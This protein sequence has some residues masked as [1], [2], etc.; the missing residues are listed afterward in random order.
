MNA[1][2]Q[3]I[4]TIDKVICAN[5]SRFDDSERGLLSQNILAQLR[6]FV[7]HIALK[8]QHGNKDVEVSYENITK[9]NAFVRS[10]GNLRFLYRF[11]DFLQITASHYTLDPENSERLML[12]YYEYLIRIKYLLKNKYRLEVLHNI[13]SFPIILDPALKEYYEKIVE[14]MNRRNPTRLSSSYTD[15]YYIQK[16]KPFFVNHEVYYEVTFTTANERASKFDRVIAFT[17]AEISPNYAV[18][19]AVSNDVIEV[20]AK[21]MPI[22]IIDNWEVS[23]RPCELDN[24]ASIFGEHRKIGRG[25]IEYRELM[26]FLTYS[27]QSLVELIDSP[28]II[29]ENI[30]G[31]IT[32]QAKSSNIFDVI[33]RCRHFV[34]TNSL[35]TNIVRYLLY[36]LNNKIIKLQYQS[37][38]C[39]RLSNLNLKWGCIPFDE[40]PFATSL[41]NHNPRI[42]DLFDSLPSA[43]REHELFARY[44]RNNIEIHSQLYTSRRELVGFNN[45]DAL[46]ENFNKRLYWKHAH[47]RIESYKE[48]FYVR[49]Y[50][51]DTH[52]II[53]RLR[54]LSAIGIK[55]YAKS[56][57]SWLHTSGYIIDCD[58]KRIALRRLF[59]NSS[60][61]LIYGS[62]GTGKSTL[63]SHISN[64]FHDRK[65]L[66][67]A[68]TNPAVDNLKRRVS[69]G[70]S[71]FSTMARFLSP[72]NSNTEYDLLVID[73]C[74]TVDNADMLAVLG[75]ASF[76]LLVLVGDVYQIESIQFGN[77][78]NMA[79]EFVPKTSVYELTKPYRSQ[80]EKLLK[81]WGKVR[82]IEDDIV[83]HVAKGGYSTTLNESIFENSEPD[84]IILCLN[85]DGLYGINNINR[86]LQGSN[87]NPATQWGVQAYKVGDPVLFN[88]SN[89]F[90]P[91][92]YNNLKGR[93]ADIQV[94]KGEAQ[95]DVEL[96]IAINEWDADGYEFELLDSAT[97]GNSVIRFIVQQH[98]NSD[99]DDDASSSAV[100]PFQISYSVSIHK[101][102]GLEYESVKIVITDET[103]EL[104]THNIFYTAITR[105]KERLKIYW[106]PDTQDRI[107]KSL[108]LRNDGKDTALLAAKFGLSS[109]P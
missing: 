80:N 79:R 81:L 8:A 62:A 37:E 95:F 22:Q 41:I 38:E 94:L 25:T 31:Q 78:F 86:F 23:I 16:I 83:E 21:K 56:V 58:E 59:E 108:R 104:I 6:N 53:I 35:G 70:N 9:A 45:I 14:A 63:I 57:D 48:H 18:K 42:F 77:W 10:R 60:V 1:V 75:R 43:N 34:M 99:E 101:A 33:D 98:R 66:Y 82:N 85:Y 97:S 36:R 69:T 20:L 11:H 71:T 61:A 2:D 54:D 12:K 17:R 24:F 13:D 26:R 103:E 72:R 30:K 100:V 39:K 52:S 68:K 65:K 47:R 5:I 88:E 74:S 87:N 102:Q 105:A 90:A 28:S 19:L 91:L 84:E 64:F 32:H 106:T 93:I 40:M 96:D 109:P 4:L 67:L 55:N 46:V 27:G 89:R 7:E 3:A 92:I 49:C 50:E 29:Y 44:I 73:E 76:K 107:L 51:D 15:R